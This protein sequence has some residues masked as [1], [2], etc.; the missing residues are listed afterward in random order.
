MRN[1]PKKGGNMK[2]IIVGILCVL[3]F[4]FAAD[5]IPSYI[6]ETMVQKQ[7]L[8][9]ER[10]PETVECV[11]TGVTHY[12][13]WLGSR[14]APWENPNVHIDDVYNV[15][16][17]LT[18]MAEDALGRIYVCYETMIDTSRYGWGLATSTD[19]GASW[20]NRVFY[21]GYPRSCR[22]PEIAISTD[23]KIWIWGTRQTPTSNDDVYWLKSADGSFNDP[24]GLEGFYWFGAGNV[25]HRTYPE[26]VTWGN[27]TQLVLSTW[28]YDNGVENV[29][30]W[31]YATDGGIGGS[32][33]VYSLSSD[34]DPDGMTSIA[35]NYDGANYIAV[36]GWEQNE[37]GDWNVMCMID[38][39]DT[40][41][42]LYG[43]GTSNSNADH[44]PSVFCSQGYAY[45]AY[46]ADVGAGNNDI[47]FN[48]ST[49]YG[50][51]WSG[52]VVNLT[53]D[54]ANETYPRLYGSGATIGV[55]YIY[56][57]NSVR[58]NYSLDNGQ[59]WLGTPEIVTDN[60]SANSSYH[61]A[62]LLYTSSYWHA[63][64]EDSRNSG[65]DGLELYASRRTQGI[66]DITHRPAELEFNYNHLLR[67]GPVHDK[68][69]MR[70]SAQT[71]DKKLSEIIIEAHSDEFIPIF[72]MLSKQLNPDYLIYHAEQMC[73]PEQRQY[74]IQECK[75]LA[76]ENQREL[77]SYL[78]A[79]ENKGK[80]CDV[81]SMWSTNT[82]CLKATFEIIREIAHRNDVW[83]I[84][85]SEPLMIIGRGVDK[86]SY[87]KVEFKPD[88][89]R[90]ICWGVAK[91]NADDVWSLG[92]TG[93]GI[94]VGHMDSG[95]NYNH[96]D[97]ADHMWDG[98]ASYPNH[99]YDFSNDDNNPMDDNGHGTQS[100]GIVA[101]DG[102]SG[103]QTG[104]APDAQIMALKIYP[105]TN[106]EMGLA[107]QF[108]LDNGADLLSCSIGWLNP[109]NSTKNWCRGQSNTVYAAGIVWCNSAG[110]GDNMG[111]HYS[112]PQDIISPADCPGPYY[113]PNGGNGASIAVG[114]TNSLDNVASF[115][116]Y[117]PTHWNTGTYTDY[118]YPPGLIK[119][120]VAA[121]GVNCKSLDHLTNDQ[122][123]N[124]INGTSFAQPHLAGTV[125]LM[126]SK[127]SALTPRQI[128]SLIQTTAVDIEIA[129]RDTL[130]GIGRIDAL[131]AVNAISGGA[132]WAQ[133]WVINQPTAT[134]ILQVS[135]ITKDSTWIISIS[136]TTFSVPIDD[137]QE[138]MVTVDTTG[139]GLGWGQTY[140]DTLL[141][142]SNSLVDDNPEK[143]PV[144]LIMATISIEEHEAIIPTKDSQLLVASPNPF[145]NSVRIDYMVPYPQN[146]HLTIHDVCGN[147]VRTLI[148]EAHESGNFSVIW[149]GRD[150]YG[151]KL[152]AGVY[153]GRIE[154]QRNAETNKLVLI[155]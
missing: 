70:H 45:I 123:D 25:D 60:T 141:I 120:D 8:R 58:F 7:V 122:Y 121:P 27:N 66:G 112:V 26:V 20:D 32:W 1:E 89:S 71:I 46:Q 34:G 93:A 129:G 114:A 135:D 13:P 109:S 127:N 101:G 100:A 110:N 92:Y 118:P 151:R 35:A 62:S 41:S 137:S 23:G 95:V 90:E 138:V 43:W 12:P 82:I 149:D 125:C 9:A 84:G 117:G 33:N 119:P 139:Q 104:V 94:I 38:T 107:I 29:V 73:K 132:R 144:I 51:N 74:V 105:G 6:S 83:E 30:S 126:L 39:L 152:A 80:V 85:Y 133:L 56:A 59:V 130:S 128:D 72:I 55:N 77:L 61:S 96:L 113:A 87:K 49:D 67:S 47:L 2:K 99:G 10:T 40:G 37:S 44:Y 16:D 65:T 108:A 131:Q 153:F 103:S 22:F 52:S 79:E 81:V 68:Y 53:N 146:I 147:K 24:D 154:T 48:Y 148:N 14:D 4:S 88:D 21:G 64:W 106:T 36:H 115:S 63:V 42:G 143:V 97:L 155:R 116:S 142:W 75:A 136:P 140:S 124:G 102:T 31:I 28:T 15:D 76:A 145:A 57:G 54:A 86:P 17:Q 150:D 3:L 69:V 19:N 98:G 50:E 134:G 111:G 11:Y 5:F 91:I 78:S 18:S